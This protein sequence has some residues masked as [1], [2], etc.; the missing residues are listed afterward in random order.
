MIKACDNFA[1][2]MEAYVSV[3]CGTYSP[4]LKS[5]MLSIFEHRRNYSDTGNLEARGADFEV[6]YEL[7]FFE[8]EPQ[9]RAIG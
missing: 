6:V 9:L 4:W 8:I 3:K 7:C 5:A 2:F 1:A